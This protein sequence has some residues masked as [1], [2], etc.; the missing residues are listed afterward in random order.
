MKLF[1]LLLISAITFSFPV[2]ANAVS[3]PVADVELP[4]VGAPNNDKKEDSEDKGK[5]N[6]TTPIPTI[7]ISQAPVEPTTAPVQSTENRKPTPT[8]V[9]TNQNP[10]PVP[11]KTNTSN[12]NSNSN[13]GNQR[14]DNIINPIVVPQNRDTVRTTQPTTTRST[15]N[16]TTNKVSPTPAVLGTTTKV[17][18]VTQKQEPKQKQQSAETPL[19]KIKNIIAPPSS[20]VQVKGANYYQDERLSPAV[21]TNLLYVAM[22]LFIAGMLILKLPILIAGAS[23]VKQRFTRTPKVEPFTIPYIDSK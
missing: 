18:T 2:Q 1:C 14:N 21:T 19:T 23:K 11:P 12:G 20:D 7:A 16:A 6:N 17:N 3:T 4:R 5:G 13:S 8:L 9:I 22:T 10:T 15:A